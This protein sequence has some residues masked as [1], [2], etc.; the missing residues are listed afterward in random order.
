MRLDAHGIRVQND[1]AM[2]HEGLSL[3]VPEAFRPVPEPRSTLR[4]R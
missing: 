2:A 1:A 4:Q 3:D